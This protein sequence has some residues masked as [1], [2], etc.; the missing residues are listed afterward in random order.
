MKI[1]GN[2]PACLHGTLHWLVQ[3]AATA[4][5]A[6]LS[7]DTARERF[8]LTEGPKKRPGLALQKTRT[9]LSDGKLAILTLADNN[10]STSILE[11]W[12]LD[13]CPDQRRTWQLKEKISM[14]VRLGQDLSPRFT[15]PTANVEVVEDGD[16][17]KEIFIRFENLIDAY[18]VRD[19][20]WRR[21]NVKKDACV[22]MHRES[23]S[24]PEV[25]FG[26][27]QVLRPQM[28]NFWGQLCYCL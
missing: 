23:V 16:H 7:F 25:S 10:T 4:E 11:M 18:N 13:D 9:V 3:S 28:D 15:R 1:G 12:V 14:L 2:R 21:V 27:G 6:I 17:G 22:L 24:P 20:A 26:E 19:K 5:V 8:R